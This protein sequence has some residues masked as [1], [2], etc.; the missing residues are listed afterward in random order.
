[1][2]ISTNE[3]IKNNSWEGFVKDI[4]CHLRNLTNLIPEQREEVISCIIK[5]LRCHIEYRK[6]KRT[7]EKSIK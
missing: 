4:E 7:I 2:G 3:W 1:M 5:S 6:E